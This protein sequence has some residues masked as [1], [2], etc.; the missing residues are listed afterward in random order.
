MESIF[1]RRQETYSENQNLLRWIGEDPCNPLN[2][3]A[4][5]IDSGKVLD[6]GCGTGILGRLLGGKQGVEI[7]GVD[8]GVPC[9]HPGIIGY[10]SF[11]SCGIE[12]LI[13]RGGIDSYD[14]I[15]LADVIE[16]FPYPDELLH[17]LATHAKPSCRFVVSTPNV[18]YL[19]TRLDLMAGKFDYV[20]SGILESTHLRLCTFRTLNNVARSARLSMTHAIFLNR[21]PSV[22]TELGG[23]SL[24]LL[25]APLLKGNDPYLLTYQFLV[26]LTKA[27]QADVPGSCS[28]KVVGPKGGGDLYRALLTHTVRYLK[29]KIA[30]WR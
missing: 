11:Y 21:M 2:Q 29:R 22:D 16:H 3:I 17:L 27:D 9:D 24:R 18:A 13:G 4:N 28:N 23:P 26:V 7:D 5:L 14:W 12:D 1:R 30:F 10:R 19:T 20:S 8:P 15:V 25:L 6:V